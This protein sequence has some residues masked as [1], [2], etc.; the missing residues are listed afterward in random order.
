MLLVD[1]LEN[2]PDWSDWSIG[3]LR[4]QS[5]VHR[6]AINP[7]IYSEL[8]LTFSTVEALDQT[9]EDLGL[10]RIE[11]QLTRI[12]RSSARTRPHL[13]NWP[14]FRLSTTHHHAHQARLALA[15]FLG[16]GGPVLAGLA[17]KSEPFPA[18]TPCCTMPACKTKPASMTPASPRQ[19]DYAAVHAEI[20]ALLAAARHAAARS[21]N[22][23]MTASYWEIG[24]RIVEFEQASKER[25]G[26]GQAERYSC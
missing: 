12:Q 11:C 3:Q 20:V 6:L 18:R 1:V 2:D 21:V 25:A 15:Y 7:V 23:V 10:V 4:A 9:I 13:V 5:K 14:A 17:G 24:R 22:T 8:S 16:L 19:T 26:Y